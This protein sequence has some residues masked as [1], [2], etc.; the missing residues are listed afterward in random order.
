[1]NSKTCIYGFIIFL[2]M[3]FAPF[4]FGDSKAVYQS[5]D[6]LLSQSW[7]G[8]YKTMTSEE[9]D[10][11]QALFE[12]TFATNDL[13]ALGQ[14]WAPYG[15]EVIPLDDTN[16]SFV[17]KE[18][19]DQQRGRGFYYFNKNANNK[20]VIQAPHQPSDEKTGKI[21]EQIINK[22]PIYAG[23]WNTVRRKTIVDNITVDSDLAHLERSYF[24][25]FSQAFAKLNPDGKI[26]QLHGFEQG[27]RVSALASSAD[28]IISSGTLSPPSWFSDYTDC[29]KV[30]LNRN[31]IYIFPTEVKDLGALKNT[32]AKQ[33]DQMGFKGFIHIEMSKDLRMDMIRAQNLSLFLVKCLKN[34]KENQ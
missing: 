18:Q 20:I 27:K 29:L 22:L 34:N 4:S 10:Q 12:K 25:S 15:Y 17:L 33:L 9:T 13:A 26:L 24:M 16:K 7:G 23:G 21:A 19:I 14:A 28:M 1:M 31:N 32:I 6:T 5:L 2:S 30:S 11:I 3:L 8:V